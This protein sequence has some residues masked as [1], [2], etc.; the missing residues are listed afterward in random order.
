MPL[1]ARFVIAITGCN[2]TTDPIRPSETP[3]HSDGYSCFPDLLNAKF[4]VYVEAWKVEPNT[5]IARNGAF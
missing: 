3:F 2:Q 4:I 5:D 1:P